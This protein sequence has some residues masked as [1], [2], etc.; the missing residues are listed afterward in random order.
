MAH[1]VF[2]C[3]ANQ[4]EEIA[5]DVCSALESNGISCWMAPRD[6]T[7]G[8]DWDK[9]IMDA[10]P[11]CRVVVIIL[12]ARSNDS[13]YCVGEIRTAFDLKKEILPILHR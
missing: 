3:Y 10:I 13:P 7:A 5:N 6:V 2:I 8:E 9:A 1:E 11:A 12:S 4:D